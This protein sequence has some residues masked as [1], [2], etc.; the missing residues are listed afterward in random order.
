MPRNL[1]DDMVN[2]ALDEEEEELEEGT[3]TGGS[4]AAAPPPPKLGGAAMPE[5]GY[6]VPGAGRTRARHRGKNAMR[7]GK[8]GG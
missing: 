3:S 2:S 5:G 1:I 8:R 4:G 6:P 7:H